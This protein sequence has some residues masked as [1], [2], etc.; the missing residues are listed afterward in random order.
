[1]TVFF[2][3]TATPTTGTDGALPS[4]AATPRA[5]VAPPP[6]VPPTTVPS[7]TPTPTSQPAEP[8]TFQ[9]AQLDIPCVGISGPITE[10]TEA[11][12]VD[13]AVEPAT[14]DTISWYTGIPGGI[15]SEAATNTNYVYGH[16]WIEPAIFNGVRQMTPGCEVIITTG[17]GETLTYVM[18]EPVFS[19]M[20]P[21]LST[22]PRVTEAKAGRL[23]LVS[24]YRPDGY[25]PNAGTVENIVA[26]LQLV[27]PTPVVADSSEQRSPTHFVGR[28]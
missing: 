5:T 2:V 14:M 17:N 3:V 22:D 23:V 9:G 7:P 8:W 6:V 24:C 18:S 20:K 16:S 15:L 11:M 1:M 12:L 4:P 28:P 21:E 10:Y 25:D 27:P 26:V 13:G 19:V